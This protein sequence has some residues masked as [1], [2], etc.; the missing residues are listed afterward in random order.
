METVIVTYQQDLARASRAVDSINKYK[1]GTGSDIIHVVV[2][3]SPAVFEQAQQ[4]FKSSAHVYHYTDI[5]NWMYSRSGW[6]NQQWLKLQASQLITGEW[7]MPFDS[8][9]YIDRHIK[10]KELFDGNRALCNLRERSDYS[11]NNSFEQ[12]IINAC[13]YWKVDPTE[14]DEILRETPPNLLNRKT[15][16]TMLTEMTPWV[17]GSINNPSIE[18]FIYWVYLHK[19]N[20]TDMYQHRDHWFWFGNAFYMDNH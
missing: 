2:N 9:M 13:K 12:Y 1:I 16:Q 18:F 4:L 7:Y 15:V 8:D 19:N 20:L 5:S 11:N 14:L 17:F 3:D 10:H 6:W